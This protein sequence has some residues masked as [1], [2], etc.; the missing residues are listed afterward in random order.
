M[1]KPPTKKKTA[2]KPRM[3]PLARK[4]LEIRRQ[5][6]GPDDVDASMAKT[7]DDPFMSM[8]FDA[9]HEWCF[10]TIWDRPGLDWK[11]RSM[12]TLAIDASNNQ[13]GAIRRHVRAALRSG[14]TKKEIG[15]IFLHVYCYAG[16]YNAM[17][18]FVT[19]KEEFELIEQEEK[20]ARA[21]SRAKAKSKK[22]PA[23]KKSARKVKKK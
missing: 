20:A 7:V 9:T 11:T 4:G 23:A 12:L 16:V 18:A 2:R 22:K 21:A 14:V 5:L 13:L 3:T 1:A 6:L 10:G 19:A 17:S 15:E 8:F